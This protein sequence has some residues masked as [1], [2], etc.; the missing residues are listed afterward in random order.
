MKGSVIR[1]LR[2][3]KGLT[4]EELGEA[5]GMTLDKYSRNL[6]AH[7][8]ANPAINNLLLKKYKQKN[9]DHSRILLI[10]LDFYNILY[11]IQQTP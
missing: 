4:Q 1:E 2:I 3:K 7:Y 5:V 11:T 10:F 8:G 9:R 6:C